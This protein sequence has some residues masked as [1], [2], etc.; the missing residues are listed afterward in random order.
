MIIKSRLTNQSGSQAEKNYLN[1]CGQKV[2][3]EGFFKSSQNIS[4]FSK[5]F[6]QFEQFT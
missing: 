4:H 3:L 6:G 2:L 5:P 1:L